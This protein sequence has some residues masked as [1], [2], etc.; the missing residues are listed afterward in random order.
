MIKKQADSCGV[1]KMQKAH[2]NNGEKNM[3]NLRK[4]KSA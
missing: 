3:R 2:E 4:T 1:L